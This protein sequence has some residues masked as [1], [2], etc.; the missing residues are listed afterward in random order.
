[1]SAVLDLL[2]PASIE[3]ARTALAD[4]QGELAAH[5]VRIRGYEQEL[6]ACRRR[7]RVQAGIGV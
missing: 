2:T 4:V 5:D 6:K 1:M 3:Q 7:N